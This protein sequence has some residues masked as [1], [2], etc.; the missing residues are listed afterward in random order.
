[1]FVLALRNYSLTILTRWY[2]HLYRRAAMRRQAIIAVAA[3]IT[4]I[5]VTAGDAMARQPC[6]DRQICVM[7]CPNP[8]GG[9]AGTCMTIKP[10]YCE[11]VGSGCS[12]PG[13]GCQFPEQAQI[14]CDFETI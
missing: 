2:R 7:I 6:I 13:F 14:W 12:D 5:S 9:E 8:P 3:A 10:S 11:L 4:A 1:M